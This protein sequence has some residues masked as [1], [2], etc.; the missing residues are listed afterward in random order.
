MDGASHKNGPDGK[1]S[2]RKNYFT[3]R[4]KEVKEERGKQE[5]Q[6]KVD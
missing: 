6:G 1:G 2:E 4:G 5:R 3:R